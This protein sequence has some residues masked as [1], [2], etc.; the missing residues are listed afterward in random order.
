M[1]NLLMHFE[2]SELVDFMNF[3]GLLIFRLNVSVFFTSFHLKLD[4]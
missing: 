2:P 4:N 3:I 1:G